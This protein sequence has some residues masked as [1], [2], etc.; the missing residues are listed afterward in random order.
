MIFI[1]D[2]LRYF[3]LLAVAILFSC[4]PLVTTFGDSE[5]ALYYEAANIQNVDYTTDPF[6]INVMTWNIRF[7]AGRL[8]FFGDACGD[9][10]V[11]TSGE[12]EAN[13]E[14]VAAKINLSDPDIVLLQEAS[15]IQTISL[16]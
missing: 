16:H 10:V 15:P 4:E 11:F 8:P 2:R 9:R 14:G 3:N 1:K 7:G 12:I 6:E 13:L 5:D